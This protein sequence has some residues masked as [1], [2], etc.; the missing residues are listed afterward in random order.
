MAALSRGLTIVP[1]SVAQR[2]LYLS[3]GV[4]CHLTVGGH[5]IGPSLPCRV[6]LYCGELGRLQ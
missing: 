4:R 1:L 6:G 2:R 5:L 3:S